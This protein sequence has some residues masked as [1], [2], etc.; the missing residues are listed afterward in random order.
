MRALITGIT[1]QDGT[2]LAE[3]LLARGYEISGTTRDAASARERLG[4]LANQVQLFAAALEDPTAVERALGT[5]APDEIYNLAGQTRV[6]PSWSDPSGTAEIN[7]VGAT[8]LLEAV[9]RT[10]PRARLFQASSCEIFEPSDLPLD[11]TARLG[12]STPYGISK[13]H[14]HLSTV[15]Y[16]E[17]YGL[18]AVSGIL[19]NHESPRRDDSFVTRKITRAAARIAAGEQQELTLGNVDVRRDWGFAGDYVEAMWKTLQRGAAED[20]VLG[21]G[22]AHSV[23]DFC[24]HA[25]KAVGLDYRKHVVSDPSLARRGDV[26]VRVADATRA[27]TRLGWTPS[28]SFP[29]LVRMMVDADTAALR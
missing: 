19:F 24:A 22:V 5:A 28:V 3:F 21:T 23:R 6:G 16:R 9:R 18:F 2:Y 14:A 13:L 8:R 11:E 7:A 1:G 15:A 27:R 17:Q 4:S 25:F 26:P 29:E 20:F 10:T 12:A